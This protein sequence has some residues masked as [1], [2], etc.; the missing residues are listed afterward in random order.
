M[1]LQHTINALGINLTSYGV[2]EHQT[3]CPQ[4]SHTRKKKTDK[5][6]SVKIDDQGFAI[7]CHHCNW[8]TGYN[9][10]NASVMLQGRAKDYKLPDWKPVNLSTK[11]MTWLV[12]ERKLGGEIVAMYDLS[13]EGDTLLFPLYKNGKVVNIKYRGPQKSFRQAKDAEKVFF[14]MQF[15]KGGDELVICEGEIDCLTLRMAGFDAVSVP[16]GAPAKVQEDMPKPEEDRKFAFLWNCKDFLDGYKTYVI[17]SDMDDAGN[18]LAEEL[19]RRLGRG[20]CKRASFPKKDA[21][22]TLREHGVEEVYRCIREAQDWP[23]L[24]V[25]RVS[26]F[27]DDVYNR[28]NGY[29][30]SRGRLTGWAALDRHMSVAD[31]QISIVTG[32][33]GSGKSQWLDGLC[34]NLAR[35]YGMKFAMCSFENMV[36]YHLMKLSRNVMLKEPR[37]GVASDDEMHYALSFLHEH[38]FFIRA[39]EETPTIEWILDRAKEAL[40]R[41]GI[42]GL[43]IDPYNEIAQNR[44][45]GGSESEYISDMLGKVKRF[46]QATGVHVWIVAHPSKAVGGETLRMPNLYDISGSAHWINKADLGIIVHRG[47]EE[48]GSRSNVTKVS[49]QK[50]RFDWIGN[51]GTIGLILDKEKGRYYE[52]MGS[53]GV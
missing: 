40:F 53:V 33:P 7:H 11:H 1:S 25:H 31:G 18:A 12:D 47:V 38:F 39:G 23:I 29:V 46:A 35:T 49:V 20:K 45:R 41:H 26:E 15:C 51:E 21:N 10:N 5:C 43:I 32:I 50:V 2:G 19:A 8:S 4:C 27:V 48:D 14:G 24:G 16:D 52:T 13:S 6:L 42:H 3:T 17:A 22:D 37:K 36:P 28:F 44:A 9:K 30:E 34:L